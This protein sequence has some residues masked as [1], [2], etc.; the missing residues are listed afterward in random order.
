MAQ[1]ANAS[2]V[3]VTVYVYQYDGA[4]GRTQCPLE[5][6]LAIVLWPF[7]KIAGLVL[8]TDLDTVIPIYATSP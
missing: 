2:Y 6:F 4:V 7:L 1:S 5:V 3:C 8:R